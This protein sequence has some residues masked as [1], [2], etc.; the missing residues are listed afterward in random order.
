[1]NHTDRRVHRTQTHLKHSLLDLMAE[2]T[3]QDITVKELVEAA[4]INRSTFYLHYHNIS[5]VLTDMEDEVMNQLDHVFAICP[6]YLTEQGISFFL[7]ELFQFYFHNADFFRIIFGPT[8]DKTYHAKIYG[9]IYQ[10]VQ[11]QLYRHLGDIC[12]N[13][14]ELAAFYLSGCEGILR[15]HRDRTDNDLI[16]MSDKCGRLIFHSL[17]SVRHT[18]IF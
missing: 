4:E 13:I 17:E 8:G 9:K 7:Y 14:N 1:M 11:Q 6:D 2:K 12:P 3:I 16:S 5:D 18:V 10:H 15:L